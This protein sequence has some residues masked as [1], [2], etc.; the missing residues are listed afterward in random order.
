[1]MVGTTLMPTQHSVGRDLK[2][3]AP[4]LKGGNRMID[5]HLKVNEMPLRGTFRAGLRSALATLAERQG[6]REFLSLTNK[7]FCV[8]LEVS[9]NTLNS[10]IRTLM[11]LGL[12]TR[13]PHAGK[14]RT[15]VV[16]SAIATWF[17]RAAAEPLSEEEALQAGRP[18]LALAMR[19]S[20]LVYEDDEPL[21]DQGRWVA[22][23][24]EWAEFCPRFAALLNY[25][26]YVELRDVI[27]TVFFCGGETPWRD[28]LLFVD[29]DENRLVSPKALMEGIST[30]IEAM[31]AAHADAK[32][33]SEKESAE[34]RMKEK[35]EHKREVG[36]G[37]VRRH[38]HL[39]GGADQGL[40]AIV[41]A[42]K[43]DHLLSPDPD[44]ER[45]YV[46]ESYIHS[47]SDEDEICRGL[48]SDASF[49][50]R[51]YLI[52]R[53]MFEDD[54]RGYTHTEIRHYEG[55]TFKVL[56]AGPV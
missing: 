14:I 21:V 31:I 33:R 52:H 35:I 1:M 47:T 4:K 5:M 18:E 40:E 16:A 27:W 54:M 8:L 15:A 56:F 24:P 13:T 25:Y 3:N 6:A 22:A 23:R 55:D 10:Y 38:V 43:D 17:D 37:R 42:H 51:F 26:S 39:I 34:E 46:W 48:S 7:E 36:S 28:R 2:Q 32:E 11:D 44:P 9:H 12:I 50:S 53:F 30:N 41:D 29:G 45:S 49:M 19:L 20:E